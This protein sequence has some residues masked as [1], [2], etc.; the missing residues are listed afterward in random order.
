MTKKFVL[1]PDSF[2]ES[3]SAKEACLAM[4]KGILAVFKDAD[5]QHVPM[6][7]G[8]EGTVD[9]LVDATGGTRVP[10]R[11]AGP[12][13]DQIVET[14]Y[15][16]LGDQETVVIE[17]A[18]A[19][20][21]ELV[22]AAERNPLITST[23]G[24]GEMIQH[25]LNHGSIIIIFGIGGSVTNDGGAG[26]IQAL[27]AR[28]LDKEGQELTRGGGALDK[29]AQIDLTQFDQRI[30]ATEV[31]VASDV[32]NP[33]TGPTGASHVFGPQ[34]GATEEMVAQLDKNLAHYAAIIKKEV[35]IDVEMMPGAGAAGGLGAGLL[36]FTKAQLRPGIDIVFTG[37]GGMDLQTKFGKAPYCVSRLAKKY[38][39]PVFACAGYI[40]KDVDVLYEE[41]MTA[42]FGILAKAEPLEA[43]LKNGPVNLERTVENIARTL[44]L[45]PCD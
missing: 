5:I 9:S 43:A 39:K 35:G 4:E 23:Y 20:G 18:K 1:A 32:N 37:E 24:T 22:K 44:Q 11:V 29:L 3:M 25:A 34:K 6:A 8:G 7:D 27:G 42:I 36:A 38:Q 41:G 16:L 31:L 45:V 28:L 10:V 15:G 17:M 21:I 12:L 19:N 14:Y 2:K 33:L 40:G 30:F 26:M 13:P